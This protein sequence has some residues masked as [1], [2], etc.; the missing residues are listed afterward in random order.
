MSAEELAAK[1]ALESLKPKVEKLSI[2]EMMQLP[3]QDLEDLTEKILP[4]RFPSAITVN[5]PE[6]R[7]KLEQIA[8]DYIVPHAFII[9]IAMMFLDGRSRKTMKALIEQRGELALQT[10]NYN[11]QGEVRLALHVNS[12]IRRIFD[13]IK[14]QHQKVYLRT[15]RQNTDKR[16]KPHLDY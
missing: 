13:T 5:D 16:R 7:V 10:M 6:L 3:P 1:Q 9:E 8:D 15:R 4:D 12:V 14:N 11:S 2:E